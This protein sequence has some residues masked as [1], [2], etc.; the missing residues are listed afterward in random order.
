M[1]LRATS[2]KEKKKKLNTK[3]ENYFT[4]MI[5]SLFIDKKCTLWDF[6]D[7]PVAKT[8]HSQCRRSEFDPWSEN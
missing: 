1:I 6:P 7:G 4:A 2:G 5:Y 3:K 8:S